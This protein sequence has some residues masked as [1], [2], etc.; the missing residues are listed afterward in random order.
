MEHVTSDLSIAEYTAYSSPH[1]TPD[2]ASW[3]E[4]APKGGRGWGNLN[5]VAVDVTKDGTAYGQP[6]SRYRLRRINAA[7]AGTI[8]I[9]IETNST[10]AELSSSGISGTV[11]AGYFGETGYMFPVSGSPFDAVT[12]GLFIQQSGNVGIGTTA[13]GYKLEVSGNRPISLD[14]TLG[15]V[16]IKAATG[17]WATQHGFFGSSGTAL[18]GFGGFG[19]SD[20]L[21]YLWAGNAYNDTTMVW[22]AG[23]VGIGTTSPLAKL[24]VE[25]S[26]VTGDTLLPIRRRRRKKKNN[27]DIDGGPDDWEWEYLYCRIDEVL[28]GDEVLSLNESTGRV[29]WHQIKNRMDMGVRDIYEITTKSGRRIRTTGNHPYLVALNNNL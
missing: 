29:E 28:P 17:G 9:Y 10:F 6:T 24:H 19:S 27:P 21:T 26:C 20:A 3:V 25:G 7:S 16:N 22:R 8:T 1:S 4:L 11:L 18:G 23:N 13:P 12:E 5:P 14:T 2:G 15:N